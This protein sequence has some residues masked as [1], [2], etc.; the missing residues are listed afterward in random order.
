METD[1]SDYAVAAILSQEDP[2]LKRIHPVA[3]FSRSMSPAELNYELYDKE[4]LAIHAAFKEWRSYLEGAANTVK[5]VTDHKNLE[6]FSTTKLLTHRQARW[7]EFLSAFNYTVFYRPGRLGGKPDVLTR[8]S[9]VYPKGGDGAYALANP[10]NMQTLFKDGQLVESLRAS[11][12]LN[13][14]VRSAEI[15]I[16]LRAT[17]LDFD[18]LRA[19]IVTALSTNESVANHLKSPL[20]PWSLSSN[21]LLLYN[22][23][24]YLPDANDLPL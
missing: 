24:G 20:V 12:I 19:D 3:Y 16:Q 21:G 10:Q 22:L 15:S 23:R 9:D 11:Y 8:R 14:G 1:A 2:V 6:Y 5:V 17:I 13:P 7:S 18:A 4:L